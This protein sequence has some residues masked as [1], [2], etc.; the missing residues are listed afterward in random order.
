MV[1]FTGYIVELGAARIRVAPNLEAE[2][3]DGIVFHLDEQIEDISTL[4]VGQFVRVEHS[5][6]MTKSLPPQAAAHRIDVL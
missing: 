4:L 6:M 3:F 5:E 1:T 2:P